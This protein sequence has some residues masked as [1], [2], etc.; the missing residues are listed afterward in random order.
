MNKNSSVCLRKIVLANTTLSGMPSQEIGVK[1]TSEAKL[2]LE[3]AT[4]NW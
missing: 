4:E 2:P 1:L 3:D